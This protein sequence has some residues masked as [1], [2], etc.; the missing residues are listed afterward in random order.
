VDTYF[1]FIDV[2]CNGGEAN[3]WAWLSCCVRDI[4]YVCIPV[5]SH[6]DCT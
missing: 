1:K 5:P 6:N 3:G 2:M 4:L